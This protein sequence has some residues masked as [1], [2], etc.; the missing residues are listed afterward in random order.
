MCQQVSF[1]MKCP[2]ARPCTLQGAALYLTVTS[3]LGRAKGPQ[4]EINEYHIFLKL[5]EQC[6]LKCSTV[7]E[8]ALIIQINV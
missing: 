2:E 8:V 4:T 1:Q 7:I 6:D 5:H 3:D